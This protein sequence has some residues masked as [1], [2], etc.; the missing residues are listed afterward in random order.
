ML[1]IVYVDDT[2]VATPNAVAIENV[3]TSLDIADEEQRHTFELCDEGEAGDFLVIRIVKSGSRQFTLSQPG[4]I[5]KVL[6]AANME[7]CN[8][9]KTPFSPVTLGK[10][11]YGEPFVED[12]EYA[13]IMGMLMYLSTNTRPDIAY[14]IH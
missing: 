7:D 9:V 5:N 4:L 11:E 6:K 14:A 3:I 10:D 12:W 1:C 2:I 13:N 8:I